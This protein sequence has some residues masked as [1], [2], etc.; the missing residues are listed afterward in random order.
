MPGSHNVSAESPRD[1]GQVSGVQIE[2]GTGLH[3]RPR[4][5]GTHHNAVRRSVMSGQMG[6]QF[7]LFAAAS[8]VA[9]VRAMAH[10]RYPI[11]FQIAT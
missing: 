1:P 5:P 2:S 7:E 4:R 6:F 10:Q 8:Y 9:L 3:N 11:V